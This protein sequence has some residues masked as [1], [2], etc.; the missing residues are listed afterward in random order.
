MSK[1][2]IH[3]HYDGARIF[4]ALVAQKLLPFQ[5]SPYFDSLTFCLSKGLGGPVGSILIVSYDF[6]ERSVRIRKLLGGGCRQIGILASA[7]YQGFKN[8]SEKMLND[9]MRTKK[10][11]EIINKLEGFIV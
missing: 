10:V 4:H 1:N 3:V 6:I 7:G 5:I 11:K 8:W 9:I 2:K